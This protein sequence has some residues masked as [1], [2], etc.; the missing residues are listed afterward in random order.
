MPEEPE[1]SLYCLSRF[2]RHMDN[3]QQ[4]GRPL[5]AMQQSKIQLAVLAF[6][7]H[8]CACDGCRAISMVVESFGR[9]H[10]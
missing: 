6:N 2:V 5:S 4:R 8:P 9:P 7:A 10:A 3:Q 1:V